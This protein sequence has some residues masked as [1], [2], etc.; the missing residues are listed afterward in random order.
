MADDEPMSYTDRCGLNTKDI[1]PLATPKYPGLASPR[2]SPQEAEPFAPP[3][4]GSPEV[5]PDGSHVTARLRQRLEDP[6]WLEAHARDCN[7]RREV[8]KQAVAD[9][10]ISAHYGRI[11]P[12][13][14]IAGMPVPPPQRL[15]SATQ[16]QDHFKRHFADSKKFINHLPAAAAVMLHGRPVIV[17]ALSHEKAPL[18]ETDGYL[19]QLFRPCPVIYID[20]YTVGDPD[21][22][23]GPEHFCV[24]RL[25]QVPVFCHGAMLLQP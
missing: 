21:S 13:V 19:E 17:L 3:D 15:G 11:N 18:H 20:G 5:Q 8:Y 9:K 25:F 24:I 14:P 22:P 12:T 16:M 2:R 6:H 23:G 10:E 4:P 7:I 1:L